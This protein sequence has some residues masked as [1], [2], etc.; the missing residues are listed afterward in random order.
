FLFSTAAFAQQI[1][2]CTSPLPDYVV[3]DGLPPKDPAE[4]LIVVTLM[5]GSYT[6]LVRGAGGS[7]GVALFELYDLD[8]A[9]SSIANLSTRGEVSSG[10]QAMIGGFIIGGTEPV[11]I[12]IR[13]LGPSLTALGVSGAL[14]DPILELHDTNG[15]LI[16][17]ND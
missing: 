9:S 11:D 7:S 13:A 5:P 1:H 10:D 15:S 6:G 16:V 17:E 3:A 14:P 8:P 12:L 2:N 4:S